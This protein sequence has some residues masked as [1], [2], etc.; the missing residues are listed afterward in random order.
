[1]I[2]AATAAKS[3]VFDKASSS[4]YCKGN[5]KLK[6]CKKRVY[7]ITSNGECPDQTTL[8]Y[9]MQ[10]FGALV[11]LVRMPACHAGGHGFESR[12]YRT[13]ISDVD[14]YQTCT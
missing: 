3:Q 4:K 6:I 14:K 1:M 9:R 5:Q 8:S 11:Q 10:Y 13:A 7:C 12:T 2:V